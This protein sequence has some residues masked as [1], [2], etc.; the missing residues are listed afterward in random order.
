[1][2]IDVHDI[3]EV[4]WLAM[5]VGLIFWMV[6]LLG[7]QQNQPPRHFRTVEAAHISHRPD[8]SAWHPAVV[9]FNSLTGDS[10]TTILKG[11][12]NE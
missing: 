7:E 1:M 9:L 4:Y 5:V 11:L 12:R 6:W 10:V 3:F 2:K 8:T